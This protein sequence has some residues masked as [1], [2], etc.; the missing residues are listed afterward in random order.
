MVIRADVK[1][2]HCGHVSGQIEGDFADP[3]ALWNYRPFAGPTAQLPRQQIRC[4][5]CNGPVF[6]DDIETVRHQPRCADRTLTA[7]AS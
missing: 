4:V 2:Y 6:L 1:C 3:R 7:I 5:R